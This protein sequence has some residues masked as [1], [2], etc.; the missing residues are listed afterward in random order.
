MYKHLVIHSKNANVFGKIFFQCK[1]I[2]VNIAAITNSHKILTFW[3]DKYYSVYYVKIRT[4]SRARFSSDEN[5]F[6]TATSLG[7]TH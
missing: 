5:L 4:V 2:I 1:I 7:T 6:R 3:N